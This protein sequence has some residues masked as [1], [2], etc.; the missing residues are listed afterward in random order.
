MYELKEGAVY[1]ELKESLCFLIF[2][3]FE[4]ISLYTYSA[5]YVSKLCI[6]KECL[7]L[8]HLCDAFP[9]NVKGQ[10]DILGLEVTTFYVM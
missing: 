9:L 10:S 7:K 1:M 4:R 6:E 3:P 2:N 8:G 5:N